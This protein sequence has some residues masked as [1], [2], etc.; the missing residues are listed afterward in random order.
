MDNVS[1]IHEYVEKIYTDIDNDVHI[2]EVITMMLEQ[3][4]ELIYW[5]QENKN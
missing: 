3:R 2:L 4:L 1:D 5:L